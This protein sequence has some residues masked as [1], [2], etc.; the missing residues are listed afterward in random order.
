[1]STR[2]ALIV[3]DSK[4]AQLRLQKI[5]EKHGLVVDTVFSAEEALGYLSYRLPVVIFLDHH[6]EGMDG[7]EALKII[8]SNPSTALVPVVMY[9]SEKGDVYV[10]Q[11]RALGA[12]DIVSKEILAPSSIE[13]VLNSLAIVAPES[14][15]VVNGA[16]V[17]AL[18]PVDAPE[19]RD[20]IGARKRAWMNTQSSPDIEKIQAQISRLFELHI[21]N[22]RHEVSENTKFLLRRIADLG[23]RPRERASDNPPQDSVAQEPPN[24]RRRRRATR[25]YAGIFFVLALMVA[26]CLGYY[27]W[28]SQRN[29]VALGQ[30]YAELAERFSKQQ[31][32]MAALAMTSM[33]ADKV[34]GKTLSVDPSALLDVLNWSM[35]IDTRVPFGEQPWSNARTAMVGDLLRLLD[36]AHF[37]GTVYLTAHAG[38]FCVIDSTSGEKVL[39]AAGSDLDHCTRMSTLD[40]ESRVADQVSAGFSNFLSS[41]P[42]LSNGAIKVEFISR[43][44]DQPMVEYPDVGA[45]ITAGQ[46][47]R[48]AQRNNRVSFS[49]EPDEKPQSAR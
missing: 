15:K 17:R 27:L 13:K 35:D 2:R 45:G 23:N 21:A 6:M 10:S 33:G 18:A 29:Q 30:R 28:L 42:V 39:P 36:I 22:V 47:N 8:K 25:N 26:V 44:Y 34:K 12:L 49:F 41:S 11:A 3:D 1:M 16:S 38:D 43:A 46:W 4:T 31:E 7:L 32:A 48:I 20:I 40:D 19:Q 9:T 14:D 5:L 24:A 37:R